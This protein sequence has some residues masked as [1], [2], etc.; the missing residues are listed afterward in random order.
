MYKVIVIGVLVRGNRI[1]EYGEVLTGG[2]FITP[3]DELVKGGY[4]EEVE[5]AP[6]AAPEVEDTPEVEEV[7]EEDSKKN[8][9]IERSKK[10]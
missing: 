4:I 3:V 8:P 9:L 2:M 7:K 6:S 1:A 10:K 5:D